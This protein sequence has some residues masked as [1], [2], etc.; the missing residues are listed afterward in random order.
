MDR[1]YVL[2]TCRWCPHF[3]KA[4]A[5]GH[6]EINICGAKRIPRVLEHGTEIPD[7]CPLPIAFASEGEPT[8]EITERGK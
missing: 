4:K 6:E 5:E 2:T 3:L 1:L 7:W 8:S